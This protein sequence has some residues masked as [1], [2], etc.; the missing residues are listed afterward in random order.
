MG[1]KGQQRREGTPFK[2]STFQ[3]TEQF[4]KHFFK[5]AKTRQA[6]RA[7]GSRDWSQETGIHIPSA[8]ARS[9]CSPLKQHCEAEERSRAGGLFGCCSHFKKPSCIPKEAGRG[10]LPLLLRRGGALLACPPLKVGG[11]GR[12]TGQPPRTDGGG[13]DCGGGGFPSLPARIAPQH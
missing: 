7:W 6:S 8:L 10:S 9:P 5:Q 4:A 2:S 12:E 1:K 13:S 11:R 3:T